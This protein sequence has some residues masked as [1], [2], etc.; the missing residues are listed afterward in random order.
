MNNH[1]IYTE[2]L[3][4]FEHGL[5]TLDPDKSALPARIIGYGEISTIFEILDPSLQGMAFKRLPVFRS[6]GEMDDYEVLFKEYHRV[7]EKEI[8]IHVPW[9]STV[10]LVPDSGN[11]IVYCV[12]EK[13]ASGSICHQLLHCLDDAS[14]LKLFH[15]V[16]LELKKVWDFNKAHEGMEV[17]VDA[18][19]SNWALLCHSLPER[20]ESQDISLAYIDTSTPFIRLGGQE[21]LN[22][23]L[24]LR[25]APS[26][27]VWLIKLVFLEDVVS[28]YYDP[29]L[30]VSDIIANLFKEGRQDLVEP[31]IGEANRFFEN[32]VP[33]LKARP[34]T[35]KEVRSYYREDAF[36]WSLYLLLRKLDRFLHLKIMRKPYP[37]I[38]PGKIRR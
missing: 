33:H 16:L 18:Q 28:R 3:K 35:L 6:S 13:M 4:R 22:T 21:Q 2:T 14:I 36:I 19:L 7:L 25:S 9:H 30:V 5:N 10:R 20:L 27:L 38:L 11:S 23:D 8:G 26:F 15:A 37:Y 34:I 29:H 31:F 32:T 1:L 17:A 24:F 12:Q